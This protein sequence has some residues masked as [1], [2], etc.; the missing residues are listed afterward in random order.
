MYQTI[1]GFLQSWKYEAETTQ[2]MLDALTDESL[3]QEIEPEHWTLGRVA[4]HIVTA[5]PFILSGT[6]FMFEVET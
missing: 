6:W 4:C 1:E 5:I 2:K 3:S